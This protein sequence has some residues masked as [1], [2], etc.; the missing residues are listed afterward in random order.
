MKVAEETKVTF[1]A[2][3]RSGGQYKNITITN[4]PNKLG[5]G[6]GCSAGGL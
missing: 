4:N 5:C 2:K 1:L 6:S 3:A